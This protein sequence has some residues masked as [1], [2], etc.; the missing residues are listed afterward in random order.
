M[1]TVPAMPPGQSKPMNSGPP[2]VMLDQTI[3][4]DM[5][6]EVVD[7]QIVEKTMGARETDIASLLSR[8]PDPVR[9]F[10]SAGTDPRGIPLSD[11]RRRR[12]SNVGPTW[13]SSRHATLA[14]Q[15]TGTEGCRSGK[16]CPI[17]PIEVISESNTAYEVQ[18]K[19]HDYFARW[20]DVASGLSIPKQAE[21]YVYSSPKQVQVLGVGQELDGGDL[22]PG[23][24]L[25]VAVLFE[26]DPE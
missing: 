3:P 21:V 15:P 11:R 20:G 19:I 5:L 1:S 16:W 24:R 2:Q 6:Y 25:P 10:E 8:Y 13:R 14:V 4:D 26:D 18:K 12:T 22:L 17:S 23:F 9:P 7:G